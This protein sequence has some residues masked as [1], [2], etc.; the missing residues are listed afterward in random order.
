MLSLNIS[1][2]G[3]PLLVDAGF[4][5]YNGSPEW[6][7]YTR[8]VQGH[9]TVR[10]NGRSQARFHDKNT[11][12]T[13]SRPGPIQHKSD[14]SIDAVE[15]YHSGFPGL[16]DCGRHRRAVVWNRKCCWLI[17]DRLEGNGQHVVESFFHFAPGRI[18]ALPNNQGVYVTTD[19][20]V[21]AVLQV[22]GID[23]LQI[24]ARCGETEPDGGWIAIGYGRKEPA[25]VVRFHGRVHLPSTMMYALISSLD[26][27]A[28]FDIEHAVMPDSFRG[29]IDK[30]MGLRVVS[31]DGDEMLDICC[32]T[33]GPFAVRSME[34]RLRPIRFKLQAVTPLLT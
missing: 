11:W 7:R 2:F 19:Q 9:N 10:V 25:P 17:L 24:D 4:Y 22:A 13:V 20:G 14:G 27:I 23:G 34:S 33:N 6:H 32:S 31:R 12:S 29:E 26:D 15:C 21:H 18:Q 3:A 1:T 5:T 16:K 8:D 28:P 30:D